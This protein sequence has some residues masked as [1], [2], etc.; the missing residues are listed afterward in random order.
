MKK[1]N[2]KSVAAVIFWGNTVISYNTI[3]CTTAVSRETWFAHM[4]KL[5]FFGLSKILY[6]NSGKMRRCANAPI[7][8]FG[9]QQMIPTK[10]QDGLFTYCHIKP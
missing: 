8:S 1:I 5:N 10:H 4:S 6:F 3:L 2:K 7:L 9:W